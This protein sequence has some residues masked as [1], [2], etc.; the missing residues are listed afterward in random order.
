MNKIVLA[1]V[2]SA[3]M[4]TASGAQSGRCVAAPVAPVGYQYIC[5]CDQ[6]GLNCQWKLMRVV[7]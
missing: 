7:R 2:L 6:R 5:F 1:A 4:V 3:L